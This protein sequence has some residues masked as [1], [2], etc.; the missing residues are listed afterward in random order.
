MDTVR[1]AAGQ[2]QVT[3]SGRGGAIRA[4][5]FGAATNAT[6][7]V[8]GQPARAGDFTYTPPTPTARVSFTVR[9]ITAGQAATVPLVVVDAVGEWPTFVG[10]GPSAF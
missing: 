2:L 10:G 6:V 5:R 4:I 7:E 8:G 1:G 9:R 3:L